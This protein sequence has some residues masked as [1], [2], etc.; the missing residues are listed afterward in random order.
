M[1]SA[2]MSNARPTAWE[3]DLRWTR[4]TSH[5][6]IAENA[7]AE[8]WTCAYWY[9]ETSEPRITAPAHR[10][11]MEAASARKAMAAERQEMAGAS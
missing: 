10:D 5:I 1:S 3:G 2:I 11:A 9:V 7:K 4:N 8:N 6:S